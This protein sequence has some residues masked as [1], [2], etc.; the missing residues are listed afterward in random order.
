MLNFEIDKLTNSIESAVTGE[1]FETLILPLE[2]AHNNGLKKKDWIFDWKKELGQ[3][4]RAVY[5]LV[6]F[7]NPKVIQGLISLSCNQDHVFMH[8]I[9]NARFNKGSEKMYLGIA[10][11]LIAFACKVAF[12]SN[13]PIINCLL[14]PKFWLATKCLLTVMRPVH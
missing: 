5:K 2:T 9:E 8:L 14:V 3:E 11:N 12:E 10:G 6:I 1:V 7:Q 13:S 4:S